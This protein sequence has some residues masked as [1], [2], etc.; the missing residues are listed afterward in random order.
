M[1]LPKHDQWILDHK[2][3]PEAI[4][5]RI[6]SL[7]QGRQMKRFVAGASLVIPAVFMPLSLLPN[8]GPKFTAIW[9]IFIGLAAI[10]LAGVSEYSA[11]IR[12]LAI[13]YSECSGD[14]REPPQQV[15][16]PAAG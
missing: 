1:K 2:D 3:D 4:E 9:P 14:D 16:E 15:A 5:K 11:E 6:D 10:M 12:T 8:V 13:L 7:I